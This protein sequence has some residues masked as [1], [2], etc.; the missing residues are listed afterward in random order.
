MSI[1]AEWLSI[2][3]SAVSIDAYRAVRETEH[4]LEIPSPIAISI[5][6]GG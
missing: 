5:L 2:E 4:S 1:A 3:A 6:F